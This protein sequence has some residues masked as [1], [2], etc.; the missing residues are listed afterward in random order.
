MQTEIEKPDDT[1]EATSRKVDTDTI[2]SGLDTD[3]PW[4]NDIIARLMNYENRVGLEQMSSPTLQVIL[5]EKRLLG[6]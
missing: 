2:K 6:R 1:F 3:L 5:S 4:E